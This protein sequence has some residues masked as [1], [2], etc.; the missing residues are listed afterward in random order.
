M[1]GVIASRWGNKG[2][3]S[4]GGELELR[5]TGSAGQSF[6]AFNLQ[7]VSLHLEG[8]ANDYVGKGINGGQLVIVPP[9]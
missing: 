9:G 5:F 7:G 2:F 6:G 4:A 1:S 3:Q 8:E